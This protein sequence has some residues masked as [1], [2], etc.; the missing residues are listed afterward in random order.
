M[1]DLMPHMFPSASP[2]LTDDARQL[3]NEISREVP[4]AAD[5]NP[6]CRPA[7]DVLETATAVEVRMDVPGLKPG[8]LRV[9]IRRNT[10][11]IAGAKAGQTSDPGR[12]H[13][14]ERSYGRFARAVRLGGAFDPTRA[15][16]TLRSGELRV[17]LPLVT[18]RRGRVHMIPVTSE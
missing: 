3:L 2:D 8:S 5:I 4:G 6:E 16:A 1:I 15:H 13:L 9:A 12:Y 17:V 7:V 18:E 10:M 14:A 11:L